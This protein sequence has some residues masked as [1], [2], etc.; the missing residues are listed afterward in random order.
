[1]LSLSYLCF[2]IGQGVPQRLVLIVLSLEHIRQPLLIL[3]LFKQLALYF[4]GFGIGLLGLALPL[5]EL[6]L[7][8]INLLLV[9]AD[10]VFALLDFLLVRFVVVNLGVQIKLIALQT[11]DQGVFLVDK[12]VQALDLLS[13]HDDL[14]L[15]V[16]D[17][18]LDVLIL[19]E[20][21]F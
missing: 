18:D 15:K 8:G 19:I 17:L 12:L 13:K 6:P 16:L 3:H 21:L 5:V 7:D 2:I 14:V 1:M 11:V 10:V 20:G 9:L 4:Q